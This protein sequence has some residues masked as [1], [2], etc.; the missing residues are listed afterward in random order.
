MNSTKLV[1]WLVV[2]LVIAAGLLGLVL[3]VRS[4]LEAPPVVAALAAQE[5]ARAEALKAEAAQAWAAARRAESDS[6]VWQ[7]TESSRAGALALFVQVL[8]LAAAALVIG[9]VVALV[10]AA[11]VR[12]AVL[13]PNS[14]GAWPVLLERRDGALAVL[15]VGRMVSPLVV[16]GP[17]GVQ[18]P[19]LASEPAQIQITSQAQA[20]G[21]MTS[22][23]AQ[24]D[25]AGLREQAAGR[26]SAG[27][28]RAGEVL[29]APAFASDAPSSGR[30]AVRFVYVKS[31]RGNAAAERELADLREFVEG[32]SVRG[33]ARRPWLGYRFRSGHECTRAR[34]DALIGRLKG[35]GVVIA[36]GQSLRLA[37]SE[38][39]ALDAFNLNDTDAQAGQESEL[40]P[41]LDEQAAGR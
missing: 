9:L 13:W 4:A 7:T 26:L 6:L 19:S 3:G 12:A 40:E 38:S 20:A 17:A 21:V 11:N 14:R 34:Y 32:A 1:A 29:Q 39:E 33:L 23:A 5:Q 16:I 15:D 37:V 35:A 27:V 8:G 30:Q 18:A 24:R 41:E 25:G 2:A 10:R 22:I 31:P 36:D 28:A